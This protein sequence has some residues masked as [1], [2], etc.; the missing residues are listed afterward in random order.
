[1]H[2]DV[3]IRSL[4]STGLFLAVLVVF[5]LPFVTASCQSR[6]VVSLTGRDLALGTEL[7]PGFGTSPELGL[8]AGRIAPDPWML[9]VWLLPLAGIAVLWLL[10]RIDGRLLAGTVAAIGVI[11]TIRMAALLGRVHAEGDRAGR[12]SGGLVHI[13][14]AVGLIVCFLVFVA[15]AA[16]SGLWLWLWMREAGVTTL[17]EVLHRPLAGSLRPPPSMEADE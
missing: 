4:V 7:G 8:E 17:D 6:E 5:F 2:A 13:D 11:G 3:R 12:Q 10:P 14:P 16:W 9:L 1:M 15:L